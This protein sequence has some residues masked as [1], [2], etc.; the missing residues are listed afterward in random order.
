MGVTA[1]QIRAEAKGPLSQIVLEYSRVMKQLVDAAKTP[2][3]TVDS[4]GPLA[5]L[6]AVKDFVRVGAFKEVVDWRQYTTI[7][8]QWATTS[9][10]DCS[11]KRIDEIPGRVYLELEERS[12]EG[13]GMDVVNSLTVYDFNADNK[14]VHLGIYLQRAMREQ[15]MGGW[16]SAGD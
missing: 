4:W 9:L 2:G 3:F 14:L 1:E 5:E 15:D 16:E 10:W 6:V 13:E 12:G 7:L 11:F 8:T